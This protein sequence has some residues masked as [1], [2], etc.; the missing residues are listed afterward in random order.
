MRTFLRGWARH[1]AGILKHEKVRSSAII[2]ELDGI[3]VGRLLSVQEIEL[4]N[5]SNE[6]I[7]RPL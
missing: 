5:Q 4:K 7:A 2:D 1:T 3:V 6:K